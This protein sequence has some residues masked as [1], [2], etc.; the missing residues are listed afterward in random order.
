MLLILRVESR[1]IHICARTRYKGFLF[2]FSSTKTND[3]LLKDCFHCLDDLLGAGQVRAGQSLLG[4]RADSDGKGVF[5]S[6]RD[7]D[8][9]EFLGLFLVHDR[10]DGYRSGHGD[11]L[12]RN[13]AT[14]REDRL[15]L[16]E[17]FLVRLVVTGA[18]QKVGVG[19][20]VD[21]LLYDFTLVDGE[22]SALNVLLAD[23]Q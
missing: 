8:F 7:L 13:S 17:H 20:L 12:S 19:V 18:E 9:R 21:D 23:H 6:E 3:D 2:V 4:R 16:T 15:G 5:G 11:G 10:G 1:A 14:R 22:D